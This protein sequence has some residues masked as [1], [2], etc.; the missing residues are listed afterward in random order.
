MAHSQ[1]ATG[2]E[3]G[4]TWCRLTHGGSTVRA[5]HRSSRRLGPGGQ[6]SVDQ[7]NA[8][9]A[10]P[11]MLGCSSHS[12]H[13]LRWPYSRGSAYL[14]RSGSK[15]SH[16][17]DSPSASCRPRFAPSHTD[18][19]RV[20]SSTA[21]PSPA[22]PRSRRAYRCRRDQHARRTQAP[23]GKSL[24]LAL[25]ASCVR[26]LVPSDAQTWGCKHRWEGMS[27]SSWE[28][29]VQR[30]RGRGV[31]VRWQPGVQHSRRRHAQHLLWRHGRGASRP[32]GSWRWRRLERAG[33]QGIHATHSQ[34]LA[35]KGAQH[36]GKY[37][38]GRG[39]L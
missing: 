35:R 38:Y 10:A 21:G 29:M 3:R 17:S 33:H 1:C 23:G 16:C 12:L 31:A 24:R 2:R 8:H 32:L 20:A 13:L 26:M 15:R 27:Q 6:G 39:C 7:G 28:S 25:A 36:R 22:R 34:M 9:H 5:S 11:H 30:V 14:R 37:G 4:S 19:P 18:S